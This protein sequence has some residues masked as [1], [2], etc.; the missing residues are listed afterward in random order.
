[1]HSTAWP[2]DLLTLDEWDALP[3]DDIY[4]KAELEEGVLRLAPSPASRHQRLS[5]RLVAQLDAQLRDAELETVPD[6]DVV[7]TAADLP[8]VRCPDLV[9]V[10]TGLLDQE[11]KRFSAA[12]VMMAVEIVSPGSERI[13]RILKLA[14]YADAGI[15]NYWIL[16]V[17]EGEGVTLDAFR[18]VDGRYEQTVTSATGSVTLGEPAPIT[19]D[20]TAL[21]P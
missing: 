2:R 11:P 1:M 13:D 20:L 10:T 3:E 9:V 6:I 17:D 15:P 14:D 4:R 7:L 19:L 12:E 5:K 8:T 16:D 18:L 21:V